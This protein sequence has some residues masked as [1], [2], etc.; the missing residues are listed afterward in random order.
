MEKASDVKALYGH[1]PGVPWVTEPVVWDTR[2]SV[3]A[4][5]NVLEGYLREQGV[6]LPGG[7]TF[8]EVAVMV[9]TPA[10]RYYF[11]Q[12]MQSAGWVQFNQAA[13][14]VHTSPIRSRYTVE[15][16][17][18]RHPKRTWRMEVMLLKSP[19][20]DGLAGFSPLHMALW[21]EGVQPLHDRHPVLPIPHLSF[22]P[23]ADVVGRVGP[24][25][26]VRLVLDKMRDGGFIIAQACQST[27]GHFW[28]LHHVD[29]NKSLYLKPRINIR[30]GS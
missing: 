1:V 13:D 23:P 28:Y 18:L 22:K 9:P 20:A 8:D 17:F 30:D 16:V 3:G 12:L 11:L 2:L 29:S 24:G 26:A 25:R 5:L 4:N 15:Y 7:C 14:L 19:A 6:H 21:P 27:Y 10:S